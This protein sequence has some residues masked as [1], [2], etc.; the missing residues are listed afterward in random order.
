MRKKILIA[1]TALSLHSLLATAPVRADVNPPKPTRG[2][3]YWLRNENTWVEWEVKTDLPGRLT[4]VWPSDFQSPG[5]LLN[6][7]WRIE[8]WPVVHK[9]TKGERL[10]AL[11]DVGGGVIM[12]DLDGSS[13]LRV[14]LEDGQICFVRA[15]TRYVKPASDQTAR[16]TART[17][18]RAQADS[19][20]ALVAP[21]ETPQDPDMEDDAAP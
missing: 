5:A 18:Q 21:V 10:K 15:N 2:G 17:L 7:D 12:K 19:A 11:P 20:K 6:M 1:L 3:D 13:W 4:P 16:E 9:F 14:Q 8:R